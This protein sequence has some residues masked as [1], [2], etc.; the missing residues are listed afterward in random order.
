MNCP[1]CNQPVKK[2]NGKE[3]YPYR[4]DLW[5]KVIYACLPCDAYV[6]CH[7]NS[8]KPLGRLANKTLR[9][10]KMKAHEA[11]DMLWK[12]GHF[13]SRSDAYAWLSKRLQIPPNET[14]IGMFDEIRCQEVV[15]VSIEHQIK[16]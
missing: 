2:T 4:R 16:G 8:D 13:K 9:L 1:Y 5:T 14:H 15:R 6:G 7:P 11:F 12:Q 3:I 10:H